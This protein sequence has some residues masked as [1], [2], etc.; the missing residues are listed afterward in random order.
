ML[1]F[2]SPDDRGAV[3]DAQPT[4][5][6]CSWS[7]AGRR[8]AWVH[9]SGTLGRPDLPR[10]AGT[11][12]AAQVQASMVI[13][14]LR[15]LT[16]IDG[17]AVEALDAAGET[18]AANGHSLILVRG[19]GQVDHASVDGG[20]LARVEAIDLRRG[21]SPL[22]APSRRPFAVPTNDQEENHVRAIQHAA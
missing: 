2:Q 11:L 3:N 10:F 20:L 12:V 9:L 13:V 8:C 19:S 17:G 4:G 21:G 14:D 16:F 18:L 5:F 7:L 22:S 15:D 6:N 1:E